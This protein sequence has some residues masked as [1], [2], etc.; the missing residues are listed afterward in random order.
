M[1]RRPTLQFDHSNSFVPSG[2]PAGTGSRPSKNPSTTVMTLPV[3]APVPLQEAT[4][5][6]A[7]ESF[8]LLDTSPE[9]QFDE[10]V[11][12]A[13][14]I[15]NAPIGL[16]SL[17][18][19]YRQWFKASVGLTVQETPR[20]ISFCTHAIRQ[21][22]LFEV[23]DATQDERFRQNPLVTGDPQIR[24]YA[25]V[26]LTVPGGHNLGTLCV[27]DRV[28]RTLT[29]E[30]R[31]A[32]TVLGKQI[33]A[34]CLLRKRVAA[35]EI[36]EKDRETFQVLFDHSP[37]AQ[38]LFDARNGIAKG[39]RAAL[40][41]FQIPDQA[42]LLNRHPA[43]FSP[44]LQPDG[45]N[46]RVR[47]AEMEALAWREGFLCFDFTMRRHNSDSSQTPESVPCEVTMTAVE[48]HQQP[49]LLIVLHDLSE[50][51]RAE[52]ALHAVNRRFEAFMENSPAIAFMKDEAGRMLYV[53]K[54][55]RQQFG[56][57][58]ANDW[59]GKTDEDLFPPEVAR[60][61]RKTDE[62]VLATGELLRLE[63]IVPDADG[64][65]RYWQSY[66]FPL[67]EATGQQVLA[68]L[69]IDIT[70]E[71]LAHNAL[72]DSEGK[73]RSTIDR[74]AEG[75]YIVDAATGRITEA[76]E[77][78]L[79]LLGY[80]RDEFLALTPS[81]LVPRR[82]R[83]SFKHQVDG[84]LDQLRETGRCDLGQHRFQ[85]KDHTT[86]AVDLR[87]TE[88]R[89]GETRLH[90]VIVRDVSV[91]SEYQNRLLA[92]Q[93]QLE[94]ANTRLQ[95]LA[96]TDRLTGANNR[97]SFDERLAEEFYHALHYEQPLSVIL[98][99]VDHFKSFNDTYGHPEGDQ[100]LQ[101]V[102]HLLQ[103]SA[104]NNDLVA[105]YG[106]EEF[107]L[108]LPNTDLSGAMALAERCRAA[109]AEHPWKLRS[110]TVSLGV[111]TLAATT[112][113]AAELVQLAD[114]ALYRSKQTGRNCVSPGCSFPLEPAYA[115]SQGGV[116]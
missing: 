85:R 16:M 84:L 27:I 82:S 77:A 93:S 17:L 43:D 110:I 12:L 25:G 33:V 50:R 8:G 51:Q 112:Q 76:N 11:Q 69:A 108:I 91:E 72:R 49:M 97:A 79:N 89:S 30:Q 52:Q 113:E 5:L 99:D 54:Q 90:A 6:N 38:L 86:V 116:E 9:A 47:Y 62:S 114:Q 13:T 56:L 41:L 75:L 15:C 80:A 71:K 94:A 57:T 26:P 21:N 29:P 101:F 98:V 48:L 100:A 73:F 115:S 105:R 58:T 35:L 22:A 34:Q 64:K 68:G 7:L 102:T 96:T 46:S 31:D 45:Q 20:D 53:N 104:R 39:N 10:L 44:E 74:L 61:L 24:F 32:L 59:V 37:D 14:V 92:Y 67:T 36:G 63:E 18:D 42:A 66:K 107:A 95:M 70:A 83:S 109:I 106:G 87:M 81:D 103:K 55:L 60:V 65:P 4:R 1:F 23:P 78:V 88:V 28:P 40:A 19:S 3:P 111:A 2:R